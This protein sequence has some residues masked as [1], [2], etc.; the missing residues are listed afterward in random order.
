MLLRANSRKFWVAPRI[1]S[2]RIVVLWSSGSDSSS[3]LLDPEDEGT[4]ILWNSGSYT[5]DT[6]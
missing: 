2:Q 6:L 3:K 1:A 5:C 4:V